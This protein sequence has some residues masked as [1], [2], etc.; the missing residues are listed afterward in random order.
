MGPEEK[1]LGYVWHISLVACFLAIFCIELSL[2]LPYSRLVLC[3]VL[4]LKV[5]WAILSHRSFISINAT[6]GDHTNVF[7][8]KYKK[9]FFTD[10]SLLDVLFSHLSSA[11]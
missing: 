11:I 5:C 2:C 1:Q 10:I 7:I 4:Y 9:T 8:G 6:A 3:S